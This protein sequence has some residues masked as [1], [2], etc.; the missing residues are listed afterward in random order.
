MYE[1][2]N[3]PLYCNKFKL[4]ENNRELLYFKFK[5]NNILSYFYPDY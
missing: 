2:K 4:F 3:I 1:L 5:G